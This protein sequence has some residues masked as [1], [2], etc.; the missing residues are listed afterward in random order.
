MASPEGSDRP[1]PSDGELDELRERAGERDVDA[2]VAA[3]RGGPSRRAIEDDHACSEGSPPY[4]VWRRPRQEAETDEDGITYYDRPL[5][6]QPTWIWTVPVYF[7]AGGVAGGAALLAAV[8]QLADRDGLDG[9]IRRAR[10][11]GGIGGA[12]GSAGLIADLGRPERF[13]NMLRVFRPSSP[14]SVGSWALSG[15]ASLTMGAAVLDAPGSPL[16]RVGD[17]LGLGAGAVAM[18]L[19]TYTAV[20]LSNTAVPVWQEIRRS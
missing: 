3:P 4:D 12:L 20:L 10:W 15:A 11:V 18:P 9:L 7:F 19:S 17:A 2:D 6:K 8:S 13:L 14:M 5:L 16:R 1:R